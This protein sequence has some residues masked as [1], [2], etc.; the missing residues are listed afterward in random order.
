MKA[1]MRVESK[2]KLNPKWNQKLNR[3]GMTLVEVIVAMAIL[4]IVIAPTLRIFASAS[5]TNLRSKQRQRATSVAEG[6][7]E[8][9]KAYRVDQLCDQFLS[10]SFKGVVQSTDGSRATA[11]SAVAVNGGVEQ[12]PMRSDGTWRDDADSYKLTAANVV[13]EGQYYDMEILVTPSVAPNVLTVENLN[14]YSD[15]IICLEE[16]TAYD[17]MA[18]LDQK[19]RQ[20][21]DNNFATY[22]P[23]ATSHTINT[24]TISDFKRV[25]DLA[26]N[27][28]GTVQTVVL[29]VT[30]TCKAQVNYNYSSPTGS[31]S[32]NRTYDETVMKYQEVLDAV[33][34]A[35]EL[36]VYDNSATIA[37]TDVFGRK[38]KLSHIY[39]YYFPAYTSGFGTGARDEIKIDAALTGLY[40][41]LPGT[42][43]ADRRS[44]NDSRAQGYDPLQITIAKQMA[45]VLTD[46]ELNSGEVGY[47]VSVNGSLTGGKAQLQTNLSE[48]LSPVGSVI[49][50]PSISTVFSSAE[51]PVREIR[52]SYVERVVL[53]YN[54]EIHV[55]EAGTT[56]EVATFI[57]TMNE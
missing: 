37:G 42:N 50:P 39:L 28:N 33:S 4:A 18:K 16:D 17:A 14:T 5:G 43:A 40:D 27:D 24:V 6:A 56:N 29:K 20:Q 30:Y 31:G 2:G 15:A 53:L 54:V 47:A 34:G 1:G 7:M 32:A 22:H 38:A 23:T 8:S 45:T 26:V 55:Y 3:K 46:A 25:I 35:E 9:L 44:V 49:A 41:Y 13:S 19:A 48:N 21:L 12:S 51:T 52:D 36:T 57:G 11:M 10:N